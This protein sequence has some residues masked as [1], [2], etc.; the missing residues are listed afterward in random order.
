MV[1]SKKIE[2]ENKKKRRWLLDLLFL[3]DNIRFKKENIG[4]ANK[5]INKLQSE[6]NQLKQQTNNNNLKQVVSKDNIG[7]FDKFCDCPHE[8]E[9]PHKHHDRSHIRERVIGIRNE[10]VGRGHHKNENMQAR[11]ENNREDKRPDVIVVVK[12]PIEKK[13]V[14]NFM[15][16]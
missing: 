11:H 14:P 8:C 15:R 2:K 1:N 12:T 16:K 4:S 10:R 13:D 9:H 7:K 6:L 5:T 3:S